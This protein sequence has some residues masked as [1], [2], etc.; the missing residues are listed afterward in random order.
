MKSKILA[1]ILAICP[2]LL[3]D[4]VV[5]RN[6]TRTQGTFVSGDS[7]T[8]T[9][10]DDR[11]RRRSYDVREVQELGFGDS[12]TFGAATDRSQTELGTD[13][14]AINAFQRLR[15]DIRVALDNTTLNAR[16]RDRLTEARE[17]LQRAAA[18]HR[19]GGTPEAREVRTAIANVR[20]VINGTNFRAQ[21]R[22]ALVASL[23]EVE[24]ALPELRRNNRRPV[25]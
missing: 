13:R 8:I 23:R 10:T 17:I 3:A 11:G 18:N 6:G 1:S 15:E 24:N 7:R 20:Y 19:N 14:G 2:V 9:F 12:A 16:E 21:D 22:T 4:T 5:L 25:N